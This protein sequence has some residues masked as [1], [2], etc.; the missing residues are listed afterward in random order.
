MIHNYSGNYITI[1]FSWPPISA[2][3][4]N[5]VKQGAAQCVSDPKIEQIFYLKKQEDMV[6]LILLNKFATQFEYFL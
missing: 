2:A 1:F 4:L 6:Q 5:S 3:V